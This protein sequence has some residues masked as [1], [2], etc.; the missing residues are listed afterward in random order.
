MASSSTGEPS[1]DYI[2]V[3]SGAG[4]G[5]LAARLAQAKQRVLLLE[6]GED[7]L[8]ESGGA[9]RSKTDDYRVP[10]FHAFASR[11]PDMR[12]DFWVRHYA[13]DERQCR[14]SKYFREHRGE[15]V[16]GVLYPRSGSLGGC[17]AHHAM[18]MVYPHHADWNHIAALT[19]DAS[20][21]ASN[22]RHYFQR[23]ERCRHRFFL[24][25]W[26]AAHGWNPSG[27]GWDG[28]LQTEKAI[29]LRSILDWRLRRALIRSA[30][31]AFRTLSLPRRRLDWL[32]TGFGD[33]N[34]ARL[35][36]ERAYGIRYAPIGTVKHARGGTRELLREV[37]GAHPDRLTIELN[38][39]VTRVL[40][41]QDPLR[42]RGVAYLSGKRLYR[43]HADPNP[44][45][46]EPRE[47]CASK[48]VIL[49]G[50]TFN[51]PQLL[52]LSGIG[53]RGVLVE[54]GIEVRQ[55]LEGV[56][57]NLQDR[58]E[59]GVVNR[60]RAEWPS[61][62]G[63]RFEVGDP[64]Y[65]R[66]KRRRK[67]VY[68]TNGAMLSVIK[69]SKPTLERPDLFC[70]ALLTDFRG[71]EPSYAERLRKLNYLSWVVLKAHTRNTTGSVR[72]RSSDPRDR[73][74]IDFNYFHDADDGD[75]EAVVAGIRF[76]RKMASAMGD[77]VDEEEV[78]GR[79]LYTDQ[80]LA[81]FVRDQAWGH[82]A[83]GTCAMKPQPDG[84][85]VDSQFRVYGVERLRVVDASIFPRIP[86]F[87]IVTSVYM[88]AEK[89]AD[90]ILSGQ[91][92]QASSEP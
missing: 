73:P 86:G 42:A 53:S 32:L 83:C 1:Y 68:T 9:Q 90:V 71:Y 82:H 59:V 43:A 56:G 85:V 15:E 92:A 36:D 10:A 29:P 35:V 84:G 47:V 58:Y 78:P 65:R 51:T 6:A 80:Q 62:R 54:H 20:W 69:P 89:A 18:I 63:A 3:G 33:P 13:D 30:K 40:L 50:G 67:G 8:D 39:L 75:L 26:L 44:A 64:Q 52:M 16:D 5:V 37:E 45:A 66:W 31:S 11:H 19:G 4:G 61:M 76:V 57:R 22:M 48:E 81:D 25:R 7:P 28:W 27:H 49:C 88:I 12:W 60:M 87:F 23:L 38:A 41:D 74:S 24:H 21:R 72:L 91:A 34:D 46:G 14:D 55:P 2:V 79:H 17:T 77:L 70:L